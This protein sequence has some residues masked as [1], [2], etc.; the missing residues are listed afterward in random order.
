MTTSVASRVTL[1]IKRVRKARRDRT[2][3][4]PVGPRT[5]PPTNKRRVAST[6]DG[7]V[8]PAVSNGVSDDFR[9]DPRLSG[10]DDTLRVDRPDTRLLTIQRYLASADNFSFAMTNRASEA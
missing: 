2:H 8:E 5:D 6:D 9:N 10:H 4:A 1:G 3:E 7:R